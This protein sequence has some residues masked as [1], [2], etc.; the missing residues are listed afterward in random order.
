MGFQQQSHIQISLSLHPSFLPI[1]YTTVQRSG[2]AALLNWIVFEGLQSP[3]STLT[4]FT[5]RSFMCSF[6]VQ[7][8]DSQQSCQFYLKIKWLRLFRFMEYFK[9]CDTCIK[10]VSLALQLAV[11]T[12]LKALWRNVLHLTCLAAMKR[13]MTSATSS[14]ML[15]YVTTWSDQV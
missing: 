3:R 2:N 8:H 5:Y 13:K 7:W 10:T 6:S 14:T 4:Y 12:A 15:S 9:T 11:T 1:P